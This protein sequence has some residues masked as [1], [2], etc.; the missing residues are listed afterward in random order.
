MFNF[1][2]FLTLSTFGESHGIAFG[3]IINNFPAGLEIDFEAVQY[4]LD[5]RKPGQ[6]AIVTQRKES[7]TVKF[8]SGIFEGKTTGTPIGFLIEN[9]NQKSKDYDHISTAY[10]PSHADFTYDQKFG[11]RDYRGGGKSSARETVNWVVAGSLAKQLLP[12]KVE[13][14]AYVSSVGDIFCEK[15]YQELDFSKIDSNNVR[16]PDSATAEKMI[17][18]I[19]EIKKEGN[20]I[21][22]T[23]TCVIKNL[24]AGIGE[25]VFGKLQAELAKAML[26]INAAKGFEYGSGFCGATMT[27]KDHNDLF[28]ENFTTQTNLSG[29]VQGGISNGMD[30]YFRVAFKPVATI[31]RP[32]KSV[33]KDGNSIIVEGKGRH[34][35]CVLPRAVPIVESLASFVLADL[36]LINRMRRI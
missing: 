30:V 9:E 6:S 4:Q 36:F 20:T 5:R 28:N 12:K 13:I 19:K 14:T 15:P 35:P 8:L 29:G 24:P 34:D 11:I 16:C 17:S 18:K 31:L 2:N 22:G 32:Q 26:S 23:I 27:G 7:D 1:G 33:D 21:G 3:G 10:R 25:P